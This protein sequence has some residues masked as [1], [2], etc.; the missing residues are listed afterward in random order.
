MMI[1]PMLYQFLA[2]DDTLFK[3]RQQC[4]DKVVYGGAG[5]DQKHYSAR[6]FEEGAQFFDRMSS[7]D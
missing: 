4:F 3:M 1:S 7:N 5:F 6:T 2:G